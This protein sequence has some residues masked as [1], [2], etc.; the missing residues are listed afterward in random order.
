MT[1]RDTLRDAAQGLLD[2]CIREFGWVPPG[3]GV[4]DDR[5]GPDPECEVRWRD[6]YAVA[7]ALG[8]HGEQER[9]L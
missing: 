8:S 7:A 4:D 9:K 3:S 2:A 5:A 6:L 1:E